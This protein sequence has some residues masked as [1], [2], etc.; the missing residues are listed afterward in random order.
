VAAAPADGYT[1]M[2]GY[3]ATHGIN[4]AM[5]T[6]RYDPLEDFA[7]IGLIGHSPSVLVVPSDLGLKTAQDLW[8]ALRQ[9][10]G[11]MNYASAG[12]GT[13]PHLAAEMLLRQHDAAAEGVSHAG[14]A[15]ALN[16]LVRGQAQWMIP[17]LFSALPYLKTG[18]LRALAVAAPERLA[19]W[20][21]VPTFAELGLAALDLTQWYGLFA[22][23]R[24]PRAVVERL[25]QSLNRVLSSPETASRLLEDGVQ[26]QTS[27]PEALTT[28]VQAELQRWRGVIDAFEI[29]EV[30]E[31]IL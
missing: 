15:P 24:T 27:S 31:S 6:L 28:H 18:K 12:E 22:P 19:T 4:P 7:P 5:Q 26:V 2:F 25:N 10:E 1:L 21:E 11:R 29:R 16:A 9:S 17:S 30:T 13:V 3:I 8:R 23:A 14:A 20:P